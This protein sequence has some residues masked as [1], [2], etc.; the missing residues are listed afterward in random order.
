[1]RYY[2]RLADS[3]KRWVAME[4]GQALPPI[5]LHEETQ[6]ILDMIEDP[7]TDIWWGVREPNSTEFADFDSI[8]DAYNAY[9]TN[10]GIEWY[11]MTHDC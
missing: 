1:M 11:C 10:E 6:D 7:D 8:E 2:Y 4:N 9:Y 5:E 3:D